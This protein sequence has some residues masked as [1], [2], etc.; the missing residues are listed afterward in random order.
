[1]NKKVSNFRKAKNIKHP[2]RAEPVEALVTYK[3]TLRQAQ[4]H[5]I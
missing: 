5:G 2:V 4:G 3:P 1:M